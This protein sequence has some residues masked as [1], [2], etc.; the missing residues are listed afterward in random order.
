MRHNLK[1][2]PRWL[3]SVADGRKKAEIRRA[4]RDFAEGDELLLYV[5]DRSVGQ[6]CVVT[7]I[8]PLEEVPG[9]DGGPYVSLSIAPRQRLMGDDLQRELSLGNFD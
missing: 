1:I 5:P 7:H 2:D 9:Y 3:S 6:L 4:D 8:L